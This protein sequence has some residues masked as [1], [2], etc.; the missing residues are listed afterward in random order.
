MCVWIYLRKRI[1]F[2]RKVDPLSDQISIRLQSLPVVA[3]IVTLYSKLYQRQ[4]VNPLPSIR[5][6]KESKNCIHRNA[7]K[8]HEWNH[9]NNPVFI[10]IFIGEEK[11]MKGGKTKKK[12]KKKKAS[13]G[14]AHGSFEYTHRDRIC[15]SH[16]VQKQ[17]KVNIYTRTCKFFPQLPYTLLTHL[18]I[19]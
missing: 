5:F 18:C 10:H 15:S 9:S 7:I 12:K 6:E 17:W 19:S 1:R 14:K 4:E 8:I 2:N 16:T 11:K 3:F 13:S